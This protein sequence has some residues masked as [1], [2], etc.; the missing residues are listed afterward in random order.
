MGSSSG[1]STSSGLSGGST[2]GAGGS[3]VAT[4]GSGPNGTGASGSPVG[5][6]DAGGAGASGADGAGSGSGVAPIEDYSVLQRN[7]HPTRDGLFL[8][9]TLTKATA[10]KMV[11][12]AAFNA[13]LEGTVWA[14]ALYIED[15]PAHKGVIIAVASSNNVYALDETTGAAVWTHNLGA[16]GSGGA[17][18]GSEF[19]IRSTPIVDMAT[20]TIYVSGAMGPG[21]TSRWEVHA[22]SVDDG[23][24]R[25]GGW[26]V[27]IDGKI[28]SAGL[29]FL[30]APHN[31]RGALSLVGGILYVPFGGAAGDC[32]PYHGWVVAI[33][34]KNPAN[35]AAWATRGPGGGIWAA[36]GMASDGDGVFAPTGNGWGNRATNQDSESIVRV[37]GMAVVDR[38]NNMFTPADWRAIDAGDDDVGG[39]STVVIDVPGATPSSYA[40]GASEVGHVYFV[41]PKGMSGQAVEYVVAGKTHSM[42]TGLAAYRSSMGTHV[43][44]TVDSNAT[45]CPA[46]AGGTVLMSVLVAPGAP[47]TPKTLWCYDLTPLGTGCGKTSAPIIT[48]SDGMN[49]LIVWIMDQGQLNA[50]DGV[51]GQKIYAGG[52]CSGVRQWNAPI[53]VKDGRIIVT[54]DGHVCA[55]KP[56]P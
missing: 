34:T 6:D 8:E 51:T 50:V 47:V 2:G 36:G 44:M 12:D 27:V 45:G 55:W 25:G 33:D 19:G 15:G 46:A 7:K 22:L 18:D 13:T 26:P 23:S 10:A 56:G 4:A 49:D 42:T 29:A 11:Q 28:S 39:T 40:V 48:T 24:A 52:A 37:T 53:A 38:A 1:S 54:G 20:R 43:A 35:V 9:P 17:C 21:V 32:G 41:N 30:P 5:N 31:Q 3:V 16:P 14:S